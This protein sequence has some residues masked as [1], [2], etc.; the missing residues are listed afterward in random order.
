MA[1][2][3]PQE[4]TES[5]GQSGVSVAVHHTTERLVNVWNLSQHHRTTQECKSPPL[6]QGPPPPAQG[7]QG[8]SSSPPTNITQVPVARKPREPAGRMTEN[9]TLPVVV[10]GGGGAGSLLGREIQ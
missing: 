4:A 6:P 1:L 9:Y 3:P 2:K 5:S 7:G 8:V 10:W